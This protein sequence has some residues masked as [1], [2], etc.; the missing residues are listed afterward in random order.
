[1]SE[2]KTG[3]LLQL[4]FKLQY[5]WRKAEVEEIMKWHQYLYMDAYNLQQPYYAAILMTAVKSYMC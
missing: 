5:H 4:E 2:R 1:M 3:I